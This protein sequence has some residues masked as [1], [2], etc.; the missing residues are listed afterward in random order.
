[1][2]WAMW[3]RVSCGSLSL[4]AAWPISKE[5]KDFSLPLTGGFGLWLWILLIYK[6]VF[7]TSKT[8]AYRFWRLQ[9]GGFCPCFPFY[10]LSLSTLFTLDSFCQFILKV[11]CSM[12]IL[13]L[14]F[15]WE[16]FHPFGHCTFLVLIF[17]F[18][19]FCTSFISLLRILDLI[20]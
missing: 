14:S 3:R 12:S 5:S 19:P 7:Q 17:L 11:T 10:S 16:F 6:Y 4:T 9:F 2:M 8:S 20:S 1:M 18:F 15:S 13:L